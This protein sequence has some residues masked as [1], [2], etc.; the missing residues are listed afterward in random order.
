MLVFRLFRQHV[1]V[2]MEENRSFDHFFGFA[3]KKLGESSL[4]PP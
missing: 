4:L 1:V 3:A 2:L